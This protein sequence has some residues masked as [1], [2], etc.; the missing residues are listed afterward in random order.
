MVAGAGNT[1]KDPAVKKQVHKTTR[2]AVTA[3]ATTFSELVAEL[4]SHLERRPE[5]GQDS[6]AGEG[7]GVER[8]S[9]AD[10]DRPGP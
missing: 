7:P 1:L 5:S 2:T 10:Q 8:D 3:V 4:R 6:S 9:P